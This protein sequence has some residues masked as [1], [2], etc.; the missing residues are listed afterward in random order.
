MPER[1]GL[2]S[3]RPAVPRLANAASGGGVLSPGTRAHVVRRGERYAAAFAGPVRGR[4]AA[5]GH[6]A[7]APDARRASPDRDPGRVAFLSG[8]A[9]RGRAASG[10]ARRR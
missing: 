10:L 3:P 9:R 5:F 7:V 4:R 8:P 6:D 1:D 2:S